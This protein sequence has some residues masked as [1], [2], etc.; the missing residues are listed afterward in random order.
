MTHYIIISASGLFWSNNDGWV[1][2]ESATVFSLNDR[3]VLNLP[4]GGDWIKLADI[5][6]SVLDNI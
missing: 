4:I 2:F 3:Y 6:R 5:E 1:D